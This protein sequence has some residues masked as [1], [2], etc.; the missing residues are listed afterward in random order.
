MQN[1]S[2][3]ITNQRLDCC[4]QAHQGKN[5]KDKKS[6][7]KQKKEGLKER[8]EKKQKKSNKD[9]RKEVI[10]YQPKPGNNK[11]QDDV[12]SFKLLLLKLTHQL[13]NGP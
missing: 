2:H 7:E 9:K 10:F 1:A 6:T 11:E 3:K 5:H 4:A 12:M 8:G 13:I